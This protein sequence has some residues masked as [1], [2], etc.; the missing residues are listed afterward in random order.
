M[1]FIFQIS[2]EEIE[3]M[4]ESELQDVLLDEIHFVC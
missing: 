2:S 4:D 3:S 1:L